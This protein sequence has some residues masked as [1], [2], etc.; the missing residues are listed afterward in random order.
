MM[1]TKDIGITELVQKYPAA[2]MVLMQS[3][4]G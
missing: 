2:A 3:G 4:M 1:I